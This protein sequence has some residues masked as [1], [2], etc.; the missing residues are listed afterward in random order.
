MN[1]SQVNTLTKIKLT[2]FLQC[3]ANLYFIACLFDLHLILYVTLWLYYRAPRKSV[4]FTL[5][6]IAAS[7]LLFLLFT[8]FSA[9]AVPTLA[10]FQMQN[11]LTP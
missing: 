5:A 7:L 2:L 6:L 10:D 9:P 4:L 1:T 11:M 3:G 8:L